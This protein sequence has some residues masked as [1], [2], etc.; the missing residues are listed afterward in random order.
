MFQILSFLNS[1][2]GS[3]GGHGLGHPGLTAEG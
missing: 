3:R 2:F 1:A